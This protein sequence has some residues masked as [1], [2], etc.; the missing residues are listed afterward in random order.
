MMPNKYLPIGIN[1]NNR[2][3]LMVGGGKVALRKIETL[4]D[5]ETRI[6]VIAP[7]ADKKICYYADRKLL[8]LK[9][10]DYKSPEASLFGLVISATSDNI[11]NET[12]YN[13]CL[14]A[15]IPVNVVDKPSLCD[16]I[17]PALVKRESLTV[18]V[19]TDGQAP[20]LS[21]HLRKILDDIFPAH[22]KKIAGLASKF[23][24]LVQ[25]R[26]KGD[27]GRK[28]ESYKKF[29]ESDWKKIIKNKSQEELDREIEKM[30]D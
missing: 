25:D 21:H 16:F 7:D 5:Y 27:T 3:C 1:L 8:E 28:A 12:V 19:S 14:E 26:F 22:W 4:L 10:R 20:F 11:I 23:R 6:T 29:L 18:A 30:L 24:N 13:D 2:S 17:F 15:G 9:K